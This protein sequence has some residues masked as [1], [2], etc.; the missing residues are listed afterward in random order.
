MILTA[1]GLVIC[2]RSTASDPSGSNLDERR[3]SLRLSIQTLQVLD[4][5]ISQSLLRTDVVTAVRT[6]DD[7]ITKRPD[8][9]VVHPLVRI[10]TNSSP[11]T[12]QLLR[13]DLITVDFEITTDP[14]LVLGSLESLS[15]RL[16]REAP[17][18]FSSNDKMPTTAQYL[19]GFNLRQGT[20]LGGYELYRIDV[21]HE[22]V[23]RYRQYEY[24]SQMVWVRIDSTARPEF[25]PSILADYLGSNKVI[26]TSYGNPYQC[27]F[28]TLEVVDPGPDQIVIE[29]RG[30]CKR[31]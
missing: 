4:T 23:K 26:Y 25:L 16:L 1:I 17:R 2:S 14:T 12:L 29:A 8:K 3:T 27:N 13:V 20:R 19:R 28:G 10:T 21:D 18:H 15:L 7:T 24:P 11:L 30:T 6:E 9:V 31:I 5:D 22:T